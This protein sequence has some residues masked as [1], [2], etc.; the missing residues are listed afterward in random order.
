GLFTPRNGVLGDATGIALVNA[1]SLPETA[2]SRISYLGYPA[3]VTADN[4]LTVFA[5]GDIE[6]SS[7]RPDDLQAQGIRSLVVQGS[8][9]TDDIT[10]DSPGAGLNRISG[11]SGGIAFENVTF[12]TFLHVNIDTA[13]NDSLG[14]GN[15][16]ISFISPLVATGLQDLNISAGAGT[17]TLDF[18]L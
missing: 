6:L 12:T 15:D 14:S 5:T 10:I 9:G 3:Q 16:T 18:G 8:D 11:T 17:N 2:P 7:F 1:V 4:E 13:T